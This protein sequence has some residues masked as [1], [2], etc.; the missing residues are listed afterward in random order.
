MKE[1]LID[2]ELNLGKSKTDE[3]LKLNK[4]ELLNLLV[5]MTLT[6]LLQDDEISKLKRENEQLQLKFD[7]SQSYTEQGRSMISAV[8]ERWHEFDA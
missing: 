3:L 1:K 8:M 7:I 2:I 5:T 6:E 4:T